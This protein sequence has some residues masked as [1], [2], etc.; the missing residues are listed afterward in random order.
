MF[1][2]TLPAI[3]LVVF[4]FAAPQA[5]VK[6]PASDANDRLHQ[7]LIEI[8]KADGDIAPE[9]HEYQVAFAQLN[10]RGPREAVILIDGP[11]YCGSGGCN[12]EVFRETVNG[13][14]RLVS[15]HTLCRDQIYVSWNEHYGW[16]DLVI[17]VSGGGAA[18]GKRTLIHNGNAYPLNPS[19]Q[20][21]F[22]G[23]P[24]TLT[25][26]KFVRSR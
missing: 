22:K 17:Q 3:L 13:H 4:P 18:A 7:S 11:G 21:E 6:K 12:I 24:S 15:R 14:F 23:D 5:P 20:P 10:G 1:Q 8:A 2:K 16:R 19:V 26:L 9:R 25:Q